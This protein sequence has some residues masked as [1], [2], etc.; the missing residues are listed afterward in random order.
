MQIVKCPYCGK[1][2]EF[3]DS[4]EI[5]GKSYGMAYLCRGCDAYVGCHKGTD[6]PLGRLANHEL[7]KW[8]MRAHAAFDL[9]WK[10]RF[11]RRW[12]AYAWLADELN[13]PAE[14]CHIGMFDVDMC[15][16]AIDVSLKFLREEHT[17]KMKSK[18][19]RNKK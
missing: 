4:I 15:Q 18:R 8:K 7:R 12:Q 1:Q 5:Y 16:K 19:K 17:A 11:M 10:C 14:Q 3:V 13:V 2:A 9:L 6:K